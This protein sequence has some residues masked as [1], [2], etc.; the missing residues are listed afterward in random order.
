MTEQTVFSWPDSANICAFVRISHTYPRE[1]DQFIPH[2]IWTHLMAFKVHVVKAENLRGMEYQQRG[3]LETSVIM[4]LRKGQNQMGT[5]PQ[6]Q[7]TKEWG[8]WEK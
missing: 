7:Y 1:E 5:M 6:F 3:I 2:Q 8:G 4:L